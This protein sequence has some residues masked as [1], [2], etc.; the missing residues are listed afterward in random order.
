MGLLQV[1]KPAEH[2]FGLVELYE[3]LKSSPFVGP[4]GTIE[5]PVLI[6]S[7]HVERVVGCTG[8]TGDNEH[9]PLWFRCREG[10]MYRCGE[11]DQIFM[12]VR[13]VYS[14]PE[15]VNALEDADVTDLFDVATL[16]RSSDMW[17]TDD[18]HQW[19]LG[20]EANR[21]AEGGLPDPNEIRH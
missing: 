7:V 11:C 5:N 4:Y 12:H 15:E 17:N 20:F 21:Y 9:A 13:V 19:P 6:P 1:N 2:V 3:Y 8:G 16:K 10:F 18:F 14:L